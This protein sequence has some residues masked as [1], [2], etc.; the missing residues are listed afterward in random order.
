MRFVNYQIFPRKLGECSL[1]LIGNLV[2][3]HADIP[4]PWIVRVVVHQFAIF[5]HN[6]TSGSLAVVRCGFVVEKV[7]NHV[8]TFFSASMEFD[9][10]Q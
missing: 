5:T 10:S 9:R 6:L 3:R 4:W 7:V 8:F 2:R 1:L